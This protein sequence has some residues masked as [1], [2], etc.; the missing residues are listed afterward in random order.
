MFLSMVATWIASGYR[1]KIIL[2]T[3][4]NGY[5]IKGCFSISKLDY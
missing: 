3:A 2:P 4:E 5:N 1:P